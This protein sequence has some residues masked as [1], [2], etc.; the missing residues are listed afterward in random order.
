M[1]VLPSGYLE[2]GFPQSSEWLGRTWGKNTGPQAR[3][4]WPGAAWQEF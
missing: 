2:I 1:G 4:L 3:V